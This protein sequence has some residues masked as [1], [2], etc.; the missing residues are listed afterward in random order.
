M[1]QWEENKKLKDRIQKLREVLSAKDK[2]ME[3]ISKERDRRAGQVVQLQEDLRRTKEMLAAAQRSG[4]AG[5]GGQKV[6]SEP[7]KMRELV[8]EAN[9][10]VE[11]RDRLAL[12]VERLRLRL[13]K[14]QVAEEQGR[15]EMEED[16]EDAAADRE[17]ALF[18]MRLERDHAQAQVARLKGQLEDLFGQQPS[19]A[20]AGLKRPGSSKKGGASAREAELEVG[21]EPTAALPRPACLARF[22]P[23]SALRH[24]RQAALRCAV[25]FPFGLPWSSIPL[26]NLLFL[27]LY[28]HVAGANPAEASLV[29][30]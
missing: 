3:D 11:E 6:L 21:R 7:Q 8:A 2:A 30:P 18:E 23:S 26:S 12:E 27:L 10:V 14:R 19:L 13:E 25:A 22:R 9:A 20:A 28:Q 16:E 4:G 17:A 5:A 24:N 29:M 15:A 1:K